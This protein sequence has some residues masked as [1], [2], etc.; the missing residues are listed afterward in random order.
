MGDTPDKTQ[1][2]QFTRSK[3][4]HE[5][6][7]IQQRVSWN[8]A[9]TSFLMAAFVS[10]LNNSS[11][12]GPLSDQAP[13]LMTGIP[14]LGVIFS[15]F[16][17]TGLSA[18]WLSQKNATGEWKRLVPDEATRARFPGVHSRR[19]SVVLGSIASWGTTLAALFVWMI[20]L[21]GQLT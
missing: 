20:L 10:L 9:S 5:Q 19:S 3:I 6:R 2:C 12:G 14:F 13:F 1:V 21:V 11:V 8:L 17:L 4:E 7:W 18:A 15:S 16:V